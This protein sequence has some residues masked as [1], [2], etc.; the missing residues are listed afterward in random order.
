MKN[1]AGDHKPFRITRIVLAEK[2]RKLGTHRFQKL[3][4]D[5]RHC[6]H[7]ALDV[8]RRLVGDRLWASL[9][10]MCS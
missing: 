8:R 10:L 3:G 6:I 5:L 7:P 9:D 4:L 1:H 2:L